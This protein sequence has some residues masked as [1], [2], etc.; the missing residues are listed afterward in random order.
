[1]AFNGSG[2]YNLPAADLPVSGQLIS[3]TKMNSV[4]SDIA[5]ALSLCLVRDGQ[6]TMTG[7]LNM[8]SQLITGVGNGTVGS[9]SIK[10]TD[11]QGFYRPAANQLALAI[12]GAN[13]LLVTSTGG[14]FTGLVK[15]NNGGSGL[16]AITVSTS[17][18]SGGADG[19]MWIQY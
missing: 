3:S 16:G 2:V 4:L 18:P 7:S 12:S 13:A 10:W 17:A 9:P 15:G 11:S 19:D 1:M 8:G 5:T 14:T 6:S